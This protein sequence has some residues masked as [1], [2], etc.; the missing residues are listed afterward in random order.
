MLRLRNVSF[1]GMGGRLLV[2]IIEFPPTIC[3][4]RVWLF[5]A[6]LCVHNRH[7]TVVVYSKPIVE[8]AGRCVCIVTAYTHTYILVH[9]VVSVEVSLEGLNISKLYT[10]Q[11]CYQF[12][13]YATCKSLTSVF[14]RLIARACST[15]VVCL[16]LSYAACEFH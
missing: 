15:F 10:Q 3:S 2:L 14:I 7:C 4:I 8:Q 12:A 9:N 13:F 1:S 16:L 5:L 6:L 11:L